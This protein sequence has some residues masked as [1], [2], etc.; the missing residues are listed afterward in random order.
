MSVNKEYHHPSSNPEPTI[1]A[2]PGNFAVI[3]HWLIGAVKPSAVVVYLAMRTWAD[4]TTGHAYPR[5]QAICDRAGLSRQ[6]VE[7][8]ISELESVGALRK[9]ARFN[10]YGGQLANSYVLGSHTGGPMDVET[11][12]PDPPETGAPPLVET[13]APPLEK[14]MVPPPMKSRVHKGTRPK[15]TR[16]KGTTPPQTPPPNGVQAVAPP[17]AAS[18]QVMSD[19][20][21]FF[22]EFWDRATHKTGK[23]AARTALTKALTKTTPK[24]IAKAW[25]IAN[26]AWQTWPDKSKAPHPATWLNQERWDDDPPQPVKVGGGKVQETYNLLAEMTPEAEQAILDQMNGT[27]NNQHQIG[28]ERKR[29]NQ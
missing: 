2:E 16:P 7:Q 15:G 9:V 29:I 27:V 6:T 23:G 11:T 28:V 18:G 25:V 12:P 17:T 1:T 14:N 13:E 3:P 24:R 21:Q 4:N 19:E 20:D 26:N 22:K 5:I 10:E 8:A